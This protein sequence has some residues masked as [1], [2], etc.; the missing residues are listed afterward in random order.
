MTPDEAIELVKGQ[1][2]EAALKQAASFVA[3]VF[4]VTVG[5]DGQEKV[6]SASMFFIDAGHGSFA[7]T[8]NH[9]LQAYVDA[10]AE[11]RRSTSAIV[12]ESYDGRPRS[13]LSFELDSRLIDGSPE[14]DIATFDIRAAELEKLGTSVVT[15]W[16]PL[17]PDV[18]KGIVFAGFPGGERELV[19]P[20]DMSFAVFPG[21]GVATTVSDRQ[22]SCQFDRNY[23]VETQGF[24]TPPENYEIGGMSGGPLFR[25]EDRGDLQVWRLAGVIK[26]G[27]P[28]LDIM[29]ASRVDCIQPDGTLIIE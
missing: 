15:L 7:V 26:E 18:G 10:K 24:R 3:P 27:S 8:A 28:S 17:P 1:Y 13:A 20:R 14:V 22:I 4:W 29:F 25:V 16:P 19:G 12:P 23:V 5:V 9:V 6:S 11:V 21:L 2:G